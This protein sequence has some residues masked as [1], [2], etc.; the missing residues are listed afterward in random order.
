MIVGMLILLLGSI[1][2]LAWSAD[3]FV[4]G[5]SALARNFG[6]S[7]LAIGVLLVGFATSLPEMLVSGLAAYQGN[8]LVGVANA[9]GSNITN[10]GLVLGLTA[11]I[12]PLKIHSRLLRREIP[13]LF[14][15]MVASFLFLVDQQFQRW[16]GVV[17]FLLFILTLAWMYWMVKRQPLQPD[18]YQQAVADDRVVPTVSAPSEIPAMK[19]SVAIAWWLLGLVLMLVSARG[20]VYSAVWLARSWGLSDT[21]IG[22]TIVAAGTSLPEL[23]ATVV[24]AIRKQPDIAVGNVIGSNIFNLLAVMA[25]P[26]LLRPGAIPAEMLYRDYPV[27]LGLMLIVYLSAHRK[28]AGQQISRGIG[29]LL[30]VCYLVYVAWLVIASY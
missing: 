30:L 24:S 25:M 6:V 19:S 28:N 26:A 11:I 23:A 22:L 5:A 10:V 3:R 12:C 4:L 9:L 18:P 20:F 16:E 15:V 21:V 13:L 2:L 1:A 7:A 8:P 29:G 27:M 17:L 14:G